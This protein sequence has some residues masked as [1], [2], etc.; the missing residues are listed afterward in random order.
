[1]N[2][3]PGGSV[4][5]HWK[6]TPSCFMVCSWILRDP[7]K[8]IMDSWTTQNPHNSRKQRFFFPKPV[9]FT[10]H[11]FIFGG[12]GG[13]F[14]KVFP[15][16]RKITVL[17][18]RYIFKWLVFPLSCFHFPGVQKGQKTG[19][20][21]K[22][23]MAQVEF[24]TPAVLLLNHPICFNTDKNAAGWSCETYWKKKLTC[25]KLPGFTGATNISTTFGK[26]FQSSWKLPWKSGICYL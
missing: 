10:F 12:G 1:M 18:R 5:I 4:N 11:I 19:F 26:R 8:P 7:Q 24:H 2:Q 22:T 20:N 16:K 3:A 14:R 17:N 6:V 23:F 13:H 21:F 15:W 9:G 25:K